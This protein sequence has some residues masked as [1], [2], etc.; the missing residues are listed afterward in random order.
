MTASGVLRAT[1]AVGL[2]PVSPVDQTVID[3]LI[4]LDEV[5]SEDAEGMGLQEWVTVAQIRTKV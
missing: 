3:G 2:F 4:V 1:L 5:K